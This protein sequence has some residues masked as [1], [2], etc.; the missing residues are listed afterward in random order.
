MA[1]WLRKR[2][3]ELGLS[4]GDLAQKLQLDGV[5]ISR[6]AISHWETGRHNIPLEREEVR[7]SLAGILKMDVEQILSL[8]GYELHK[9]RSFKSNK[10]ASIVDHLPEEDQ[11]LILEY[12]LMIE[13]RHDRRGESYK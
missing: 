10:I 9:E 2:R 11:D 8:S 7:K 3:K 4:Q 6:S 1:N 12:A 13:R 5:D